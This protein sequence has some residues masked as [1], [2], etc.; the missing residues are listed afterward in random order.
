MASWTETVIDP[1]S[2]L[3]ASGRRSAIRVFD[4]EGGDDLLTDASGDRVDDGGVGDDVGR[5]RGEPV[6][7]EDDLVDPDSDRG[8]DDR[9]TGEDQGQAR[10]DAA[11]APGPRA[12]RQR[13]LV[14]VLR[15]SH[16]HRLPIFR[17]RDPSAT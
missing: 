16:P 2:G 15:Q 12:R 11:A 3:T 14:E 5:E 10:E 6:R 13:S 9:Q 7:V 8:E 1:A 17:G 4:A